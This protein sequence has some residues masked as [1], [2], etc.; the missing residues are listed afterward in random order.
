MS[1]RALWCTPIAILMIAAAQ[2]AAVP[3][4]RLATHDQAPYGT[5]LPDKSFDGVAVRVMTCVFKRLNREL[6]LEV[7]PWE[8]AQVFAERGEYDGFFPAT[9]KPE[10][11]VWAAA[12][13]VI[14]DQKWVWYMMAETKLDTS[15]TDFKTRTKV[16]AHFGSN[17]LKTLIE[18]NYNVVIKPETDGHLLKALLAGRAEAILVGDLAVAEAIKEQGLDARQF[19]TVLAKD[20]PLHAYFGKKFLEGEDP[21]FVKRFNAQIPSCR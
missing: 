15:S 5:Y 16:G 3:P 7:L 1:P 6:K 20:S 11:L 2:A 19:R 13:D 18:E 21:A 9:L 4:V 12:T 10:R 17:R 14:A 8:R